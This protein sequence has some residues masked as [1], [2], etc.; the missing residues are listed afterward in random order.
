MH[1]SLWNR[2]YGT[3][4]EEEEAVFLN[5]ETP[6]APLFAW[7]P[8][9]HKRRATTCNRQV[10]PRKREAERLENVLCAADRGD[11]TFCFR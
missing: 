10:H 5:Q 8:L 4:D 11:W 3:A 6:Y 9:S 7:S 2:N 1:P